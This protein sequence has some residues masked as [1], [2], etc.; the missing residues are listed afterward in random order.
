MASWHFDRRHKIQAISTISSLINSS[1]DIQEV[2]NNSLAAVEHF[3][4]VE[5]SS[6][7]QLDASTGE[8][9]FCCARGAGA[10]KIAELRLTV[11]EGIAGWVAQTEKPLIVTDVR[12]DPRFLPSFDAITGFTT[13]SILGVPLKA[14]GRLIG[15]LELLNKTDGTEFNEED[16]EIMKILANQIA[17]ALENARLYK[18][19]HEKLHLT[20][21]ELKFTQ[22]KLLQSER[23][24]ALGKLAQGVA[25]EVRNPVAIIGGLAHLIQKKIPATDPTQ[26]LLGEINTAVHRLEIMVRE[27]ETF[28]QM[29]ALRIAPADVARILEEAVS[30]FVEPLASAGVSLE[31]HIPADPPPM[32]VDAARLGQV[33]HLLLENSLEAMPLGG[34][35]S[36]SLALERKCVKISLQDTGKG[37]PPE[38]MP[39]IFDPFFSTKSRGN[40]M[41][42]TIV[43]RIISEHKGEIH[44][45][46]TPGAGTTVELRLP[47][48]PSE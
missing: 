38:I 24:A 33:F 5:N 41:G 36:L 6:I 45:C 43:H 21:E 9:F 8:L 16:L 20:V 39:L 32:P 27:I 34:R 12:E 18:K 10:K 19:V 31:M 29:P 46:S 23:L 37:I 14:K 13:R 2:L 35:L 11:G 17:T 30:V 42:L 7:F 47:R 22:G 44:I 40:G 25:H 1:L 28:A 15:V 48:W 26:K 3:I 4:E